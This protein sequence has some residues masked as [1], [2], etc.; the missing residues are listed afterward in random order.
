MFLC[1]L[2]PGIS[3]SQ[4][5]GNC[6]SSLDYINPQFEYCSVFPQN[7]IPAWEGRI[8]GW[9]TKPTHAERAK[10]TCA[11]RAKTT[12]SVLHFSVTDAE[13]TRRLTNDG[14]FTE[15]LV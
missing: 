4:S 5:S 7:E 1:T 8:L 14:Q 12:S 13:P 2:S 6:I 10:P 9:A 11:E 3:Y 15:K